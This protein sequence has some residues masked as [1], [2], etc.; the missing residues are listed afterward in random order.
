[1]LDPSKNKMAGVNLR[2]VIAPE[3]TKTAMKFGE[4]VFKG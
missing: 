1:M 4:K 3:N 2:L